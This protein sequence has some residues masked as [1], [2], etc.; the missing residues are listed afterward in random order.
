MSLPS[1]VCCMANRK[2][3]IRIGKMSSKKKLSS[4]DNLNKRD[5]PFIMETKKGH[6]LMV[7][8]CRHYE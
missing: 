1:V 8:L 5:G 3:P 2:Y 4:N 7:V 6:T